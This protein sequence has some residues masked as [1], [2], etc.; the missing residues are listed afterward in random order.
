MELIM[1]PINNLKPAAYNP[2]TIDAKPFENLQRALDTYGMTQPIPVNTRNM[3]IIGG[4]QRW[5]A[6]K[7]LA[8]EE[9]PVIYVE[10]GDGEERKLN[11]TLNSPKFQGS[12]DTDKLSEVLHALDEEDLADLDYTAV[13]VETMQDGYIDHD[14]ED[15]EPAPKKAKA[16]TYTKDDMFRMA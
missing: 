13:E 4:R 10:L 5:R 6:A 2:R 11:V 16:K 9:V 15:D 14:E 8:W 3:P 1:V 7:A 12:F